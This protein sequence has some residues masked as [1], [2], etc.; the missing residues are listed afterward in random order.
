[1]RQLTVQDKANIGHILQ[2]F[3]LTVTADAISVATLIRLRVTQEV[4][5]YNLDPSG[6]FRGLV[7][8]SHGEVARNGHRIVQRR[9]IDPE[10]QVQRALEAFG[11]GGFILLV[12]DRQVEHLDEMIAVDDTTTA[13]F[14]RLVPLVGG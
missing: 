13:T 4:E 5:R 3:P 12:N 1:M 10:A 9:R 2:Q 8:L 6:G 14:M 7:Q 11:E